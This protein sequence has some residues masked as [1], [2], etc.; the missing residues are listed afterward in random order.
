MNNLIIQLLNMELY[1]EIYS[2]WMKL[3]LSLELEYSA[4]KGNGGHWAMADRGV[5]CLGPRRIGRLIA[6]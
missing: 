4:T 3:A 2:T 5:F 1:P 6:E